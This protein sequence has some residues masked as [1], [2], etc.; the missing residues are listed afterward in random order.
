[1]EN[2]EYYEPEDE[3]NEWEQKYDQEEEWDRDVVLDPA[4]ERQQRKVGSNTWMSMVNGSV[5]CLAR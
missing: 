3:E 2:Y 5:L 1:M 4:W